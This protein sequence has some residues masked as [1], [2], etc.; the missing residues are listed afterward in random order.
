MPARAM[1]HGHRESAARQRGSSKQSRVQDNSCA[2]VAATVEPSK[3]SLRAG[4]GGSACED[5]DRSSESVV[6]RPGKAPEGA[7]PGPSPGRHAV[8]H[9]HRASSSS[10]PPAADGFG[11]GTPE[12]NP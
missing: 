4:R 7:V 6:R 11:A 2:S 12:P 5:G 10:I 8:A 1:G 3:A 9:S